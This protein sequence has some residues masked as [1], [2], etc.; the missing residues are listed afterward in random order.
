MEYGR[1]HS[2]ESFATLDGVGIRYA[3]FFQGCPLRC[4]V[5]H[6]PDT[7][8]FEGGS[9]YTARE[10]FDKVARYKPYFKKGGGITASGGEP[11]LQAKFLIELF[12]L[13]K[14]A[15]INIAIDTSGAYMNDDVKE[16]VKLSDM[17]ILDLKF[18][19]E[20]E[21]REYAK[22]SLERTLE[23]LDYALALKKEVWIRTVIIPGVNDTF[24]AIDRYVEVV[25]DRDIS[26]YELLGFH[27]MGF[28]KYRE[29]G[30]D[31]PL[32]NTSSLDENKLKILEKYLL[33]RLNAERER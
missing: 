19:S 21:Y 9:T 22:G 20:E 31:N 16:A 5:C 26:K 7:W 14:N 24:E 6:N 11:L 3:I 33:D 25:K 15:G 23:F 29:L 1:I 30:I 18:P 28:Y 8:N 17:V 4:K 32:E 27:T 10:I 12:T 2:F 13:F